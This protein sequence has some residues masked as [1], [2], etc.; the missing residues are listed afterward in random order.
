VR[1]A[2]EQGV[3]ADERGLRQACFGSLAAQPSVGPTLE[4]LETVETIPGT[5]LRRSSILQQGAVVLSAA[6]GPAAVLAVSACSG[7]ETTLPL[8]GGA[9]L[10]LLVAWLSWRSSA[11]AQSGPRVG[12]G[13]ALLFILGV[14][15]RA[16]LRAPHGPHDI[17]E[18]H[19]PWR[20]LL[21]ITT[22]VWALLCGWAIPICVDA[23]TQRREAGTS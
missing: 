19:D 20:G 4:H 21:I 23:L 16:A 3:G 22:L 17:S 2:A 1:S 13:V 12:V 14:G 6:F 9:L 10:A 8:V 18:F 15:A 5:R 7:I 11:F